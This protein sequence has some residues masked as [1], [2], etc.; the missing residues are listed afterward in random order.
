MYPH[1][2]GAFRPQDLPQTRLR[3][4]REQGRDVRAYF[5]NDERACAARDARWRAEKLGA[6][7]PVDAEAR[8][9]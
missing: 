3:E 7:K 1:W 8:P 2:R 6:A 9:A 4:W 5:D